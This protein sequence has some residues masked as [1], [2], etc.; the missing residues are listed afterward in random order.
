MN[1]FIHRIQT[2]DSYSSTN[3]TNRTTMSHWTINPQGGNY[4]TYLQI[5]NHVQKIIQ[6]V[7]SRHD[8]VG[9][10]CYETPPSN[11]TLPL[12]SIQ[13]HETITPQTSKLLTMRSLRKPTSTDFLFLLN[14][15]GSSEKNGKVRR[16]EWSRSSTTNLP[17]KQTSYSRKDLD[18]H[19]KGLTR[20]VRTRVRQ[21]MNQI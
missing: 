17:S 18:T 1:E 4:R 10:I 13:K 15:N 8:E 19:E 12:S 20:G 6:Q 14:D 7:S 16:N 5:I 21:R 3:P 11:H 2:I 9:E